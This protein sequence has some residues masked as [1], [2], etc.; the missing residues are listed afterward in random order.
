M[1]THNKPE[2]FFLE[3][4]FS[5][6]FYLLNEYYGMHFL[7]EQGAQLKRHID[8][9][10]GSGNLREAVWLPPGEDLKEWLAVYSMTFTRFYSNLMI[11]LRHITVVIT[12]SFG[13]IV[14]S[15]FFLLLVFSRWFLQPGESSLWDSYWILHTKYLPNYDSW[16]K[17]Q[18]FHYLLIFHQIGLLYWEY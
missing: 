11:I 14:N 17:V 16:A 7:F 2:P 3:W 9:T 1:F 12:V 10:L 13:S 8:A 15:T 4:F 6:S 5:G 18:F